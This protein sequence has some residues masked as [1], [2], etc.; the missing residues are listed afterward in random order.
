MAGSWWSGLKELSCCWNSFLNNSRAQNGWQLGGQ[1]A[2]ILKVSCGWHIA[3]E[4]KLWIAMM[5]I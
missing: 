2:S 5:L 1:I 3:E 4:A